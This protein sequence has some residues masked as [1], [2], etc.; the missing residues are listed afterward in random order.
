MLFFLPL[1]TQPANSLPQQLTHQGRLL[2]SAG[3][4][5]NGQ[6]DLE[7]RIYDNAFTGALLWEESLSVSFTNGYY[8]TILGGDTA[9]NPL[10]ENTLSMS[11]LYL[12]L[13][14]DGNGPLSPRQPI[15]TAPY[16]QMSRFT[17]NLDG[18]TVNAT[19][20]SIG[21]VM[22]IDTN[23]SWVG[24]TLAM[25]WNNIQG[26]PAEFSDGDDDTLAGL[27]CL[28]GQIVG[29]DGNSW[30]CT[31][32]NGLS[33]SQVENYVTN[34]ALDFAPG[35]KMGG[36]DLVTL[37]TDQDSFADLGLS[38]T[39][40]DI[41]KW[42]AGLSEWICDVDTDTKLSETE[43]E[44]YISNG[45]I[46]LGQ[47]TTLNGQTIMTS[48]LCNDGEI[49]SQ[50]NGTWVCTDF[51]TL[52]DSDGDGILA[53]ND[54]NDNDAAIGSRLNDQDCDG[55]LSADDCDDFDPNSNVKSEDA[56]C[57]GLLTADD[58]NDND[59]QAPVNDADCDGV[60]TAD[61]C[62]DTDSTVLSKSNDAD[63]DG[64]I[65]ADDCDDDNSSVNTGTTGASPE[66]AGLTCLDIQN[67]GYSTGSGTYWIDPAGTGEF[68]AYCEMSSNGGGWTLVANIR[69]SDTF[70]DT[71]GSSGV[72]NPSLSDKYV[73]AYEQL[74]TSSELMMRYEDTGDSF[75][76]PLLGSWE[77]N[78]TARRRAVDNGEY[79][80][81]TT[82]NWGSSPDIYCVA[83][84][85]HS[86][87]DCDGDGGQIGGQGMFNA[88]SSNES[89]NCSTQA[90]KH[91]QG[92]CNVDICNAQGYA[93]LWFR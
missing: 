54:C 78:G 32:D 26:I 25:Q 56:D 51:S 84:G 75:T 70:T 53:W 68:Q 59:A 72:G 50:Q 6:H 73:L 41:A 71:W 93:S 79:L 44:N 30:V 76:R 1:Q 18:G 91:T 10:D 81:L 29:W 2:D 74:P 65:S 45:S 8:S 15:N 52:L 80:L 87:W 38:C 11:P 21:G 64:Y 43:V 60:Q 83:N 92:G 33:E 67:E 42:D 66:C 17:E 55:T 9:N 23:G 39:G 13:E 82:G 31:D 19:Q 20:V 24:P 4:A 7:A 28:V 36:S 62:D 14:I 85:N 90:W 88:A 40:G 89:C 63:C 37:A 47:G 34:G 69:F 48:T 16:A 12:E 49:L 77:S 58:C 22:V 46:D 57:D 5:I 27:N 3:A 86:G 35:S 61:D